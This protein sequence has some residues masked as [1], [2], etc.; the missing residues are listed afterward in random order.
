MVRT[1][2]FV[3]LAII[4][5]FCL[6]LVNS[7]Y[8][9]KYQNTTSPWTLAYVINLKNT[10][11]GKRRWSVFKDIPH[12]KNK[13]IRYPAIHGK[14]YDYNNE[15]KNNIITQKWN[16]GKWKYR[17]KDFYI[18]MEP[19]EIGVALSHYNIWKKISKMEPESRILIL[20]DDAIRIDP[21]LEKNVNYYLSKIPSD[22]DIFLLGFWLHKGDDGEQIN[23]D[24]SKVN[25]FVLMNSYMI[26]PK[27]AQ[28]LLEKLP[29]NA[30]VDTWVSLQ[31]QYVN[32][33]RHHMTYRNMFLQEKKNPRSI[34]IRTRSQKSEIKHTNNW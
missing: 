27:G 7:N 6:Y 20:E 26:T 25:S 29:I 2:I 19:G 17:N 5:I 22:W 12:F 33:Y 8:Y 9:Y 34:L 11:E 18:N 1:V 32:I 3:L 30:P 28:K 21:N 10:E 14:T 13:V 24:I 31:S 23:K 15:I 16:Y 4:V